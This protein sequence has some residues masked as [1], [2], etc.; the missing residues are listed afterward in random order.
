M[1]KVDALI[2]LRMDDPKIDRD[3]K[4][5]E[6]VR[7][8]AR[9]AIASS[10]RLKPGVTRASLYYKYRATGFPIQKRRGLRVPGWRDLTPWM[11]VQLATLALSERTYMQFKLHIH[12]DLLCELIRDGRDPKKYLRDAIARH[13]KRRFGIVPWFFFLME[14]RAKDGTAT[15]PHAHG[16]I[17]VPRSPIPLRGAGSRRLRALEKQRGSMVAEIEA[18]RVK[19]VEALKAAGGGGLPRF[20]VTTGVDQCRNL[21]PRAP[22]HPIFNSQWVDYAFKHA[23]AVSTSLGEA[24]LALPYGLREEAMNLWQLLTIGEPAI[25]LWNHKP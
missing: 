22:Y 17:E 15:R 24:R 12:D 1:Q 9:R 2:D 19:V 3:A 4:I 16:S 25:A 13:L 18:G 20:A 23:K 10:S 8:N 6:I 21:W 5:L 14:D 11:K 7:V